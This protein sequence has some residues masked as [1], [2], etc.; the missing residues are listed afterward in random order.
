MEGSKC[1]FVCGVDARVVLDKQSSYVHVLDIGEE[2]EVR[3][4]EEAVMTDPEMKIRQ[5][6]KEEENRGK[7]RGWWEEEKETSN[8]II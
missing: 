4:S 1:P 5:K 7:K 6:M 8:K 3:K 2:A